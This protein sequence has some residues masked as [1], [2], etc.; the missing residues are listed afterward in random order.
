MKNKSYKNICNSIFV[1]F[2]WSGLS[3]LFIA[4]SFDISAAEKTSKIDLND[5]KMV[6]RGKLLYKRFCSLCHGKKLQGQPDWRTRKADGK[7]PAPP[8]D[9]SGHTWHHPD[10]VLFA[11]TKYGLVPP[12]APEGYQSDM[13]GWEGTLEDSDIWAVLAYIKS[14]WPKDILLQQ[15]EINR[16][17]LKNR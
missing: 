13:P 11:I 4:V 16:L 15:Q 9:D 5:I 8:H 7:L 12:N 17:S 14:T 3:V 10:S 2:V 1:C 6:Q